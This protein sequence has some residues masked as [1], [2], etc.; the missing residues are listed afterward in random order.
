MNHIYRRRLPSPDR[1]PASQRRLPPLGD[2]LFAI[3]V[4]N[5]FRRRS[6]QQ[7][8][9]YTFVPLTAGSTPVPHTVDVQL[10]SLQVQ[11][12]DMRRSM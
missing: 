9:R 12:T 6:G 11:A 3:G 10:P 2:G 8:E 7:C 1:H 4:W 5:K